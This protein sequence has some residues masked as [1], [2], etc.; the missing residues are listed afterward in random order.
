MASGHRNSDLSAI[1]GG[2]AVPW[3]ATCQNCGWMQTPRIKSNTVRQARLHLA[4]NPTHRATL[5]ATIVQVVYGAQAR[6]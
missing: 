4:A 6:D 5:N 3:M 2:Y 1:K